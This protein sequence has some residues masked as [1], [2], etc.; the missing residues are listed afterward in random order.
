[1]SSN[2]KKEEIRGLF[3]LG[4]LA[5][6]VTVKTQQSKIE[7]LINQNLQD[8]TPFLDVTIM[9]WSLYAFFMVLGLSDDV[10]GKSVAGSFKE[11][12]TAFLYLNFIVLGFLS[13]LLGFIALPTRMPW[14]LILLGIL[15]LGVGIGKLGKFRKLSKSSVVNFGKENALQFLMIAMALCFLFV[16]FINDE[17]LVVPFFIVGSVLII[18]AVATNAELKKKGDNK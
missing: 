16:L 18:V 17:R 10:I 11:V 8:V 6:L 3:V 7:I 9:S 12:A 15:A 4:L 5:V 2:W 14:F 13:L 1:L